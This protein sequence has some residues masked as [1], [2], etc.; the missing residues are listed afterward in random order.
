[1]RIF[2][3]LAVAALGA[4][5]AAAQRIGHAAAPH[6]D[7]E[8]ASDVT[9]VRPGEA[10][11]VGLRFALEDGWH[12]YWSNPGDSGLAPTLRWK[13]PAG[14]TAGPLQWPYPQRIAAGP[15]VNYG[16]EG[17]ALL[18]VAVTPATTLPDGDTLHL[19]ARADWLVCKEDCL[20]GRADL[21]LDLPVSRAPVERDPRWAASFDDA[22]ARLPGSSAAVRL[23]AQRSEGRVELLIADAPPGGIAFFPADPEHIENA[24]PQT[25]RRRDGA[26]T[27]EL[28]VSSQ[29][30]EPIERLRGTLVASSGFAPDGAAAIA[31]DVPVRSARPRDSATAAAASWRTRRRRCGGRSPSP[32]SAASS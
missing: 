23:D 27:L 7:V 12:V 13:L 5:P 16:Y 24:A 6:V 9:H 11:T 3:L 30:R 31:V 15:L 19:A 32:S 21:A 25:L 10:F 2:V 26:A 28:A 1:V 18:P 20:P 14:T 29:R 17:E 8:L 4:P 22:R